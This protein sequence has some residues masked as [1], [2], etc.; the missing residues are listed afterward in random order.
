MGDPARL[1]G[2][3]A[4]VLNAA[5][6]IGEATA[7]TLAKHGAAVIAADRASSGVDRH[8][9]KVKGVTGLGGGITDADSLATLVVE[10]ADKLGG[11]DILVNNFPLRPDEPLNQVD[12]RLDRLLQSREVLM[13]AAIRA[14]MPNLSR[15]PQGRIVN[16]GLLRSCFAEEGEAAFLH[17]ERDLR[18]LTRRLAAETSEAG[19]NTN[20]VQP[21]AIMTP[22]AREVFRRYPALRDYCINASN[23]RRLGEPIDVAK[24]V[25]FLVSE[26]AAFV[27]GAG[28]TVDGGRADQSG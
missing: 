13:R 15:S 8:F 16:V 10:A 6:G 22:A 4:L 2:L 25:L 20:Y 18:G 14:A 19:I 26:D 21:G 9:G 11:L 12:V 7:R 23:A 17:S 5:S 1:Y 3:N 28:V 27:S 24:V